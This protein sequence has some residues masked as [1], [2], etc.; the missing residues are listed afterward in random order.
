[1]LDAEEGRE[2]VARQLPRLV[3]E[4]QA[5]HPRLGAQDPGD[6]GIE[7]LDFHEGP[8]GLMVAAIS[9]AVAAPRSANWRQSPV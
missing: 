8:L 9:R 4:P 5:F 6:L 2:A 7:P 3:G 1:M